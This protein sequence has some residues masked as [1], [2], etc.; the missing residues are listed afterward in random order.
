M[1]FGG[2]DQ[3][4][5]LRG[6]LAHFRAFILFPANLSAIYRF[7]LAWSNLRAYSSALFAQNSSSTLV[8]HLDSPLFHPRPR[9]IVH[10][11]DI[12][13]FEPLT[14]ADILSH[15]CALAY[16]DRPHLSALT[17][18]Q[19]PHVHKLRH[20]SRTYWRQQGPRRHSDVSV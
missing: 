17:Y 18:R 10:A 12:P 14:G 8:I 20:I 2:D 3:C 13:G 11:D 4:G 7:V 1:L 5:L 16:R 15:T 19:V 6:L 9:F